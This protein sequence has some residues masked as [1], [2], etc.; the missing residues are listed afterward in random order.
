MASRQCGGGLP[1]DL[2]ILCTVEL[3]TVLVI[4]TLWERLGIGK[5][6]RTLLGKGKYAVAYDQALLAMTPTAS[7]NRSP[8]SASGTAG[9]SGST[10]PNAMA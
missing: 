2:E 9:W 4:E 3:G 10:C 7:A 1:E 8:S 6:L 5:T